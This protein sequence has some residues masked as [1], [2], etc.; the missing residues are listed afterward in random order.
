[1]NAKSSKL[2]QWSLLADA[3]MSGTTGLLLAF[4]AA[5]LA[6]L[7]GLPEALL[8]WVGLSLLPFAAFVGY[9]GSHTPS[10]ASVVQ[11]VIWANLLWAV[12]SGLII[13]F[14]WIEPNVLGLAFVLFQAVAVAAMAGAQYLGLRRRTA[15]A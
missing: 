10:S 12:D 6:A 1:M 3:V 11:A 13:V 15:L 2:L 14:G 4:A 7:F 8:F 9:L 5:P